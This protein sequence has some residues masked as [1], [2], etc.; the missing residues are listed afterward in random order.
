MPGSTTSPL[1]I[2]A[3]P[4]C[5]GTFFAAILTKR[6]YRPPQYRL[7]GS[8]GI[9]QPELS[10]HVLCGGERD[11]LRPGADHLIIYRRSD[12]H[13]SRSIDH[14]LVDDHRRFINRAHD[15]AG[16]LF[17]HIHRGIHDGRADVNDDLHAG[18]YQQ[19]RELNRDNNRDRGRNPLPRS[20]RTL[21]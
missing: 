1:Y 6:G 3:S 10:R 21:Q 9:Q 5:E 16:E 19:F 15:H 13:R 7:T 11:D 8:Y 4:S 14:A 2:G 20:R 18:R 17:L 12:H